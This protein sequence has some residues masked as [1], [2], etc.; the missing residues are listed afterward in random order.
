MRGFMGRRILSG[1]A[2]QPVTKYEGG[3]LRYIPR[4]VSEGT[5]KQGGGALGFILIT[6]T[7]LSEVHLSDGDRTELPVHSSERPPSWE[8]LWALAGGGGVSV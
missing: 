3:Q 1:M 6:E 4:L 5:G 2:V 7:P 8:L